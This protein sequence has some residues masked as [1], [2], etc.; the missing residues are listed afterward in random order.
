MWLG[1]ERV[2]FI[3]VKKTQLKIAEAFVLIGAIGHI[4]YLGILSF[5]VAKSR[6]MYRL[7]CLP[8]IATGPRAALHGLFTVLATMKWSS[9]DPENLPFHQLQT[10]E[11]ACTHLPCYT[12]ICSRRLA[13]PKLNCRF[14][15][16]WIS[17]TYYVFSPFFTST[18]TTQLYTSSRAE[19]KLR[20]LD[21]WMS[22]TCFH[23]VFTI[24]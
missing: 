16:S 4:W 8:S 10:V 21:H 18:A 23:Q 9:F 17:F 2:R 22:M 20:N 15:S 14:I 19:A 7:E 6:C 1:S 3:G 5:Y 11:V 24:L 13:S 12:S